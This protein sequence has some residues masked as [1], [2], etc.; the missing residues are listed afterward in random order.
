MAIIIITTNNNTRTII[1]V[2]LNS[3]Y[4]LKKFLNNLSEKNSEWMRE[5]ERERN[6]TEYWAR[7]DCTEQTGYVD[8]LRE[9]RK[10]D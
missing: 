6:L 3:F 4:G 7:V 2:L 5:R 10:W 8:W 9:T 1:I